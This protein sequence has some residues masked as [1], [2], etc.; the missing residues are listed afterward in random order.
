[1]SALIQFIKA[2]QCSQDFHI[3]MITIRL[4]WW[5]GIWYTVSAAISRPM[6]ARPLA[7][8]DAP[9]Y[10]HTHSATFSCKNKDSIHSANTGV[11]QHLILTN[12]NVKL[13]ENCPKKHNNNP[14]TKTSR[15]NSNN[16]VSPCRKIVN[17]PR[18]AEVLFWRR[19]LWPQRD[20]ALDNAI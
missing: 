11:K 3:K 6:P 17:D 4:T 19:R 2:K 9:V 16:S 5:L 10:S 13:H 8:R 14:E 15:T 12:V 1:M 20:L 18:R 7:P